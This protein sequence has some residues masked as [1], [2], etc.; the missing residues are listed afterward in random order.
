M[1]E[2]S[3][4]R[5]CLAHKSAVHLNLNFQEGSFW[6]RLA[7]LAPAKPTTLKTINLPGGHDS[8]E[9][10][11]CG[12]EVARRQYWSCAAGWGYAI[13]S[14]GLFPTGA[15]RTSHVPRRNYKNGRGHG[16]AHCIDELM[17]LLGL[18]SVCVSV[19]RISFPVVSSNVWEWRATGRRFRQVLLMDEPFAALDPVMR[20]ALQEEMT[21][22]DRLLGAL[23]CWSLMI[24]MVRR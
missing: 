10:P 5:N 1:I 15:W 9:D 12:E 14:I 16:S 23:L 17:T 2:F 3:H 4:V 22:I 8:G 24:L 18:E 7:H 11:L 13:Q 21:R 19:I 20:G 6:C